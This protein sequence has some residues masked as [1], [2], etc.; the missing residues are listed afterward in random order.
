MSRTLLDHYTEVLGKISLVDA[1]TFRK[2]LRK[3]FKQLLPEERQQL[4]QWF[5]NSCVCKWRSP[6]LMPVRL[7]SR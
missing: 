7:R 4:K 5:R 2:E 1:R 3:A 6:Q